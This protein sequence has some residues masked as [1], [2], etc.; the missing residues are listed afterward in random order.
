LPTLVILSPLL[1]SQ[2]E[3]SEHDG[4]DIILSP[5]YV[6]STKLGTATSNKTADIDDSE[7]KQ[8]AVASYE[9]VRRQVTKMFHYQLLLLTI[10][11]IIMIIIIIMYNTI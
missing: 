8:T 3:E 2:P 6:S 10:N 9:E 4:N 1:S 7:E 5:T 11:N